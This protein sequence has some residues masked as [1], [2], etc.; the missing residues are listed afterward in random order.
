MPKRSDP[1]WEQRLEDAKAGNLDPGEW[2]ELD[3]ELNDEGEARL[4]HHFKAKKVFVRGRGG[5]RFIVPEE[6]AKAII[7]KIKK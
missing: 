1:G 5:P 2:T 4:M 6:E 3:G 7:E